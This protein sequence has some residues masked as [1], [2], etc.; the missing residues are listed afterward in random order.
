MPQSD[1]RAESYGPQKLTGLK[2]Y[3]PLFDCNFLIKALFD[4]WFT[5]LEISLQAL[6]FEMQK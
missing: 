3:P 1:S 4:E 5:P 6:S 2:I